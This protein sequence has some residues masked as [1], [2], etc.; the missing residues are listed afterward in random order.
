AA[1]Q[2]KTPSAPGLLHS[3]NLTVCD[4]F[5]WDYVRDSVHNPPLPAKLVEFR[6]CI[7]AAIDFIT[8]D[9]LEKIWRELDHQLDVC[10]V[11]RVAHIKFM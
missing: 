3:P 11:T 1:T 2:Q 6:R 8:H 10:R 9:L 7:T 5:L 4:F